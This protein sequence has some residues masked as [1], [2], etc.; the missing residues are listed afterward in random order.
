MEKNFLLPKTMKR[1]KSLSWKH[2]NIIIYLWLIVS[3]I[4]FTDASYLSIKH[5]RGEVPPCFLSS[6][7]ETVTTSKY[8]TVFTIP[9]ALIGSLYYLTVFL[10]SVLYLDTKRTI[11]IKII[12]PLTTGGIIASVIFIYLQLFVLHAICLYCVISAFTSTG[13]FGISIAQKMRKR[14]IVNHDPN[15]K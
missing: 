5:Y 15:L 3:L 1:L 13:L 7:C 4:G 14:Q 11:F 9:V 6:G 10:L 12:P 8:S 2:S